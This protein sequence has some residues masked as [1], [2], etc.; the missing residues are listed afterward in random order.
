MSQT[1]RRARNVVMFGK[2]GPGRRSAINAIA[3][4]AVLTGCISHYQGH[5][6][7]FSGKRFVLYDTVDIDKDLFIIPSNI[8]IFPVHQEL[9][10]FTLSDT[11]SKNTVA[12]DEH[13]ENSV[14]ACDGTVVFRA[15]SYTT[16]QTLTLHKL[17]LTVVQAELHRVVV[18]L[19]HLLLTYLNSFDAL[20][21]SEWDASSAIRKGHII[22]TKFYFLRVR[23]LERRILPCLL[24]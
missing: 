5:E 3:H 19:Q 9:S 2:T 8:I 23:R 6:V 12:L 15:R 22:A 7:E 24:S 21:D 11:R 10:E 17:S 13:Q 16:L 1:P 20:F 4:Q 14:T 18:S